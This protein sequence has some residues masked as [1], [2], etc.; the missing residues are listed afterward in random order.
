MADSTGNILVLWSLEDGAQRP[1]RPWYEL[2][3]NHKVTPIRPHCAISIS[4]EHQMMAVAYRGQPIVLWDLRDDEYDGVC[5]KK[6]PSGAIGPYWVVD[7]GLNPNVVTELLAATYQDG[8]LVLF[9]PFNIQT[10][11]R[12]RADCRT[13]AASPNGH[14]L[15]VANG[16][17]EM[18]I[19][20]FETLRL[21][22]CVKT[23]TCNV[24]QLAFS[25]DSLRF[26]DCRS[27]QYNI[28]E[29]VALLRNTINDYS[30]FSSVS[31]AIV[32]SSTTP[33]ER[34]RIT[35]MTLS[36]NDAFAFCGKDDGMVALFDLEMGSQ[37]NVLY[38]HKA[39]L[40]VHIVVWWQEHSVLM[41]VDV[42][43]STFAWSIKPSTSNRWIPD[44]E[45]FNGRLDCGR[46]IVQL[47]VI[48]AS[49]RFILSTREA[50][51]LWNLNGKEEKSRSCSTRPGVRRWIQ[52]P[53]SSSH[54]ICVE[55]ATARIEMTGFQLKWILLCNKRCRMLIEFS[56][57][58]GAQST[59]G[60][61]PLDTSIF[62]LDKADQ[63]VARLSRVQGAGQAGQ[64]QPVTIG[65]LPHSNL[66]NHISH[67]VGI[68][69][70]SKLVSLD[71]HSWICSVDLEDRTL[72]SPHL[73]H[74]Y[75]P[76]DWCSGSKEVI[77]TVTKE[78]NG[79]ARDREVL[80]ARNDELA[81]I[82]GGFE[83]AEEVPVESPTT[84]LVISDVG[85]WN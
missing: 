69:N 35:A 54:I 48:Q 41:S 10:L 8:D 67:N 3:N 25:T 9:D 33:S 46:S 64:T 22:Y 2:Q 30:S 50:D 4:L 14:L 71:T 66:A 32:E 56:E 45:V 42:S 52:H 62:S 16:R 17:G 31:A 29:P 15:A 82:R 5:G 39:H 79:H 6:L 76:H 78:R 55:G 12:F 84:S 43:N 74:F 13:L 27:F 85:A 47:F 81:I 7:L 36:L 24:K 1:D 59:R 20:Q 77:C 53:Q 60:I 21:L 40:T 57:E 75:V 38:R 28:W 65:T 80:L 26:L 72:R 44:A 37:L 23:T 83:Y 11:K 18:M 61:H 58:D 51:Y 34:A 73:R 68:C 19:Y 63:A 70:N 49:E